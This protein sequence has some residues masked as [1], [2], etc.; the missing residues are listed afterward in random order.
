MVLDDRD[1]LRRAA[2]RSM[3]VDIPPPPYFAS[4]YTEAFT[5][6]GSL[7]AHARGP[8]FYASHSTQCVR[9]HGTHT[10]HTLPS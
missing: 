8:H 5:R 10:R 7:P 2:D 3:A 6:C 4:L 1:K 9:P